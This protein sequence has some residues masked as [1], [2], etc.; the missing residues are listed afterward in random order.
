MQWRK[1]VRIKYGARVVQGQKKVRSEDEDEENLQTGIVQNHYY[2]HQDRQGSN[3]RQPL[4]QV[5]VV[6]LPGIDGKPNYICQP[7]L[8][9]QSQPQRFIV[10]TQLSPLLWLSPLTML[11]CG[12]RK[13]S[14]R[15]FIPFLTLSFLIIY[16]YIYLCERV[17]IFF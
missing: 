16:I 8:T 7:V 1:H 17:Y 14:M 13:V 3:H 10:G 15:K 12:R 6:Q 5:R 11:C 9:R 2:H 4:V